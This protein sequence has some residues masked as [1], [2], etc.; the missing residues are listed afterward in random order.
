M[1]KIMWPIV[2]T[3]VASLLV[4]CVAC[5]QPA[6]TPAPAPAQTPAPAPAAPEVIQWTVQNNYPGI[7]VGIQAETIWHW[8][9]E[10]S[11][12]RIK[13]NIVAAPGVVPVAESFD[14]VSR[15]VLDGIQTHVVNYT[16]TIPEAAILTG[17]PFSWDSMVEAY[18][19]YYN[20]G[21]IDLSEQV[22]AKHNTLYIPQ[23]TNGRRFIGG[24]VA[25]YTLND[26]R[27]H[28]LRALGFEGKYMEA[29]GVNTVSIPGPEVYNALKLG[30]IEGAIWSVSTLP[31]F[32]D[33]MPYYV[34]SPNFGGDNG[35]LLW[36]L[37]SWNALPDDLRKLFELEIPRSNLAA[38]VDSIMME[39]KSMVECKET[40]E[41]IT[42]SDED[43]AEAIGVAMQL[44]DEL[45]SISPE[46]NAMI[47]IIKGQ[48]RELG[49][50]K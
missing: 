40:T 35:V 14:A 5:A 50:L 43:T 6:E 26:L 39:R 3:V 23:I 4:L 20:R 46:A 34:Y 19:C 17:P 41:F 11:G 29:L 22:H 2:I 37:D 1:R 9:E 24:T 18:D 12:G 15:G 33:V 30:T 25:A 10:V 36:S 28:K 16:Q 32:K 27:G 21:L 48:M 42:W 49:K 45:A 44:Y 38:A 13:M 8:M 47:E 31:V 7:S